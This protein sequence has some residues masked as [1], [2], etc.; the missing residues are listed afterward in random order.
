MNIVTRK[1]IAKELYVNRWFVA[2]GAASGVISILLAATGKMGFNVGALT[3]L[4][5]I[6]ATGVMLG[7]YGVMN[8]RKE[9]ALQFVLSLP[10]SIADYVRAKMLG[11]SACFLVMWLVSSAAALLLVFSK[12]SVPDGIAPYTVLLCVFMLANF[13]VVLCG[14][15]HAQS[16]ALTSAVIIVTNMGVSIFMFTVA[17][18]PGI[19]KY[20]WGPTPVWTSTFWTVLGCELAVLVVAFTLPFFLAARRRDFL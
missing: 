4:T 8:E 17:P 13:V 9:H 19:E 16:E 15:I 7:I 2:G 14:S 1:L 11:L 3:W 10:L 20:M 18:L 5:A 12:E 6:I